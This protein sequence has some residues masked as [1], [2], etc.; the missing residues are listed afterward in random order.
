M[1]ERIVVVG[2]LRH[3]R[4]ER[5]RARLGE[6]EGTRKAERGRRMIRRSDLKSGGFICI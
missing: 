1:G 5:E 2:N 3:V 6:D 4:G